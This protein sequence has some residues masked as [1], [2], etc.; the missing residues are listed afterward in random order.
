MIHANIV[1]GGRQDKLQHDPIRAPYVAPFLSNHSQLLPVAGARV[2]CAAHDLRISA[3]STCPGAYGHKHTARDEPIKISHFNVLPFCLFNACGVGAGGSAAVRRLYTI[4]IEYI[5]TY[6]QVFMLLFAKL[7]HSGAHACIFSMLFI[8][9]SRARS[10]SQRGQCSCVC[11]TASFLRNL[12][13]RSTLRTHNNIQ[14]LCI[15][16]MS[17]RSCAENRENGTFNF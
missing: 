5:C 1:G 4:Y 13:A 6:M 10:A 7:E 11:S 9:R 14:P 3:R 2:E 17:M 12:N 15:G 16:R 8:D